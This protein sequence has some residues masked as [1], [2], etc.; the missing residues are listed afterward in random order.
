[1]HP[2]IPELINRHEMLSFER[3]NGRSDRRGKSHLTLRVGGGHLGNESFGK[4]TGEHY[5]F[6]KKVGESTG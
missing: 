2:N 4:D 5:L 6:E 3:R 1:M